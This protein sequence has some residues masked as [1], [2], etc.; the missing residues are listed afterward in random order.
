[1]RHQSDFVSAVS[2]EIR[3]PLTSIR[4]LGEMLAEGRSATVGKLSIHHAALVRQTRRLER[5][6]E[7]LLQF[8][9]LEAGVPIARLEV[10][11]IASLLREIVDEFSVDPAARDHVCELDIT[12]TNLRVMGDPSTLEHAVWNVLDNAAKY[13]T[14]NHPIRV[15]VGSRNKLVTVT[16]TDQGIGIE[17]RDQRRVFA[18]FVRGREARQSG[19]EGNGIGLTLV[20]HIVAAHHGSARI[21]SAGRGRGTTVILSFPSAEVR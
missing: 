19:I 1:M 6:V 12:D 2:H 7:R 16:V 14:P 5:T 8:G 21:V 9:Q 18:R 15:E 10:V 11:D 13:S 20:R 4:Q 17:H 3:T